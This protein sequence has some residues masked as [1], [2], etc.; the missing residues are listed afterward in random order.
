MTAARCDA[1]VIG[2]GVIGAAVALELQRAGRDV[3]VVDKAAAVGAATTSSSA[4][5]VRFNFS[6]RDGVIASWEAMHQWADWAGHL[7]PIDEPLARYHR[8]GML[9][10]QAPG[11]DRSIIA[12]FYD[13]LGIVHEMLDPAELASRF[14]ALDVGRYFP[15]R[16]PDDPHFFDDADGVIGGWW[17]PDAG[18]VDDPQLAASNLMAAARREG[19]VV[20]L[21]TEVTAIRRS[22]GRI[23]GVD[24]PG[25]DTIDAPVVVNCAG[26]WSARINQLAGVDQLMRMTTRSLRQEIHAVAAPPGFGV[27]DGGAG[28]GD[29]DLGIYFR[30]HP[31]GTMLVGGIEAECDHLEWD[32]DPDTDAVGPSVQAW[33]AQVYRLARR[34]PALQVPH[35][36][37]GIASHYDVTPDWVPI[38]DRS[39]VDGYYTAIGTSGNQFKNAPLV[40]QIMTTLIDACEGGHEHDVDPVR[41]HCAHTATELNLGHYSRNREPAATSGTVSG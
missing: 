25:G 33:E 6:T 9:F 22:D 13:E 11:Y 24:L 29:F 4:A 27:E 18:F 20:R 32:E 34:L 26:P 30:P 12:A 41:F 2:A 23:A 28:V 36:P 19:T 35:R 17:T 5:V 16:S 21:R 8:V 40:G 1:I 15:P 39:A 3:I 7:G 31:G 37:V 10:F 38:Y 14:P